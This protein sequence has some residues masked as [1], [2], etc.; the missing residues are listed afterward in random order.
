MGSRANDARERSAR[1]IAACVVAG[2]LLL[3]SSARC[4]V[5]TITALQFAAGELPAIRLVEITTTDDAALSSVAVSI[6]DTRGD[7]S[8]GSNAFQGRVCPPCD[9]GVCCAPWRLGVPLTA[10]LCGVGTFEYRVCEITLRDLS[11]AE[12]HV[13]TEELVAAGLDP[14]FEVTFTSETPVERPAACGNTC[15]EADDVCYRFT[16]FT[17]ELDVCCPAG[18]V[19]AE[20]HEFAPGGFSVD[21]KLAK[22]KKVRRFC[23]RK[24]PKI[25]TPHCAEACMDEPRPRLCTKICRRSEKAHCYSDGVCFD[26]PANPAP[27]GGCP[28]GTTECAGRCLEPGNRC[29][30]TTPYGRL[31]FNDPQHAAVRPRSAAQHQQP[32]Q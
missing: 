24:C 26:V 23:K 16:E 21:C 32:G 10:P 18:T 2:A 25:V 7:C 29:C 20:P 11:G 17:P 31:C 6:S 14:T 8:Q 28:L 12:R 4:D 13:S 27:E 5:P 19:A 30:F 22:P 1:S 3:P 15:C 9:T